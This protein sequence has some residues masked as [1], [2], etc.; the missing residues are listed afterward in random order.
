MGFSSVR[1]RSDFRDFWIPSNRDDRLSPV[2]IS[3]VIW[4]VTLLEIYAAGHKRRPYREFTFKFWRQSSIVNENRGWGMETSSETG[5]AAGISAAPVI[6]VVADIAA[7]FTYASFQNAIP[8]IR[9][10]AL[11]N[12]TQQG[13]EKCTL[14]LTSN[15]LFCAP[16][17]GQL[18]GSLLAT[19][20]P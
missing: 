17:A 3:T 20:F 12:P 13:F 18:I 14:E 1:R 4:A 9:S 10:I 8:V 7:S 5:D 16:K 19:G 2:S 6:E 15:P 11:N